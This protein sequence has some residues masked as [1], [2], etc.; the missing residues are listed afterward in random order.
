VLIGQ[1]P[2]LRDAGAAASTI[3][4]GG[5]PAGFDYH[6]NTNTSRCSGAVEGHDDVRTRRPPS[7]PPK[8]AG[9]H[10]VSNRSIAALADH[11]A[12]GVAR[13]ERVSCR[14]LRAKAKQSILTFF[15]L[16]GLLRFA[17]NDGLAF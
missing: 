7:S 15:V 11:G 8:A 5:G 14:P 9:P 17:R 10:R 16:D 13:R 12:R 4:W 2:V 3:G 1:K 6:V